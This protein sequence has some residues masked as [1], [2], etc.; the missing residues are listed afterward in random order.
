MKK[1]KSQMGMLLAVMMLLYLFTGCGKQVADS[2]KTDTVTQQ[3]S[4]TNTEAEKVK[5]SCL[6]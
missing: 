2:N 5:I 1:F 6:C 3:S 4:Q